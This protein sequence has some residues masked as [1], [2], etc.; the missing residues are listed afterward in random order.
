MIPIY[1]KFGRHPQQ[2]L[3]TR[4][5][6]SSQILHLFPRVID[7]VFA[8]DIEADGLVQPR[9]HISNDCDTP[10]ADMEGTSRIDTSNLDL[11]LA[12]STDIEIAFLPLRKFPQSLVVKL[13]R[14]GKVQNPRTGDSLAREQTVGI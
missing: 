12:S 14:K 4:V 8:L 13:R 3:I 7:V 5:Q 2:L 1:R 9:Q 6:R 10:V 11:H